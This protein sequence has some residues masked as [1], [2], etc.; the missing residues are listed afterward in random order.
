MR[1]GCHTLDS[2]GFGVYTSPLGGGGSQCPFPT[3]LRV[4]KLATDSWDLDA[5][6]S[7]LL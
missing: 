3:R 5:R 1:I 2:L 6:L 4:L 7:L